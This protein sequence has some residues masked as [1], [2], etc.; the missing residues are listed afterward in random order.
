[1]HDKKREAF[2]YSAYLTFYDEATGYLK[3]DYYSSH[4]Q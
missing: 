1:M 4:S 3:G 2:I